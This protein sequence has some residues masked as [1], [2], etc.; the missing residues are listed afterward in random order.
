MLKLIRNGL[1]ASTFFMTFIM[2]APAAQASKVPGIFDFSRS[3]TALYE[4]G[5][6]EFVVATEDNIRLSF[7]T[8]QSGREDTRTFLSSH[9]AMGIM[10]AQDEANIAFGV[11]LKFDLTR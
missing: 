9:D 6:P 3:Y 10:A 1:V 2:T 11:F 7:D 4:S 8:T 5:M